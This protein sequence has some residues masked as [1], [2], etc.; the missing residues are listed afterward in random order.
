MSV[1]IDF[2]GPEKGEGWV[3]SGMIY[4]GVNRVS[5]PLI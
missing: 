5:F 1:N 2:L 3:Q 4:L